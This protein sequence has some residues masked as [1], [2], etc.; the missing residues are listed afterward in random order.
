MYLAQLYVA[1]THTVFN[2][3][4]NIK[5]IRIAEGSVHPLGVLGKNDLDSIMHAVDK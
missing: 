2:G 4:K 3:F 5:Q 1:I